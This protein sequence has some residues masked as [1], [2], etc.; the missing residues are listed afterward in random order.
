ME[1]NKHSKKP[2]CLDE[3]SK[4]GGF[5][6]PENYFSN[7]TFIQKN[8]WET[9]SKENQF[10]VPTGYFDL[11]PQLIQNRIAPKG[12]FDWSAVWKEGFFAVP[13][14][15][16]EDLP[17]RIA[18]RIRGKKAIAFDWKLVLALLS[19]RFAIPLAV[20]CLMIG[21]VVVQVVERNSK[22]FA[23][24]SEL[25]DETIREYLLENQLVYYEQ[26]A[27]CV[28]NTKIEELESIVP[29]SATKEDLED[30]LDL[31]GLDESSI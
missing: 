27:E 10:S 9:I 2:I 16:F 23:G 12:A 8:V 4:E 24:L 30:N 18:E 11:L 22:T 3:I 15:Y 14:G 17:Y 31:S 20:G 26:V 7:T 1:E 19:P 28:T 25:S 6:V 29:H 21:Y 5:A 13:N